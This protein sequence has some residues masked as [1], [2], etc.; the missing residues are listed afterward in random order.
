MQI[1]TQYVP[2]QDGLSKCLLPLDANVHPG[3]RCSFFHWDRPRGCMLA[4]ASSELHLLL[5]RNTEFELCIE[6]CSEERLATSAMLPR[7][8][9]NTHDVTLTLATPAKS[10]GMLAASACFSL[11][12]RRQVPDSDPLWND[13]ALLWIHRLG[14]NFSPHRLEARCGPR[15]R[16]EFALATHV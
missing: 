5:S 8:F 2:F 7:F 9:N 13:G 16:M 3:F 6:S 1:V 15:R 10:Q 14:L 4:S 12:P 11:P